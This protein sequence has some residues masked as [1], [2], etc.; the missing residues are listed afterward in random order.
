MLPTVTTSAPAP[1]DELIDA[2]RALDGVRAAASAA[3]P[4]VLRV[5]LVDGA[6]EQAVGAVV[7]ALLRDRFG[8]T[9]ETV[10]EDEIGP[11]PADG[12]LGLE[13]LVLTS[14][15]GARA[16][17]LL[18]LDGR[19]APGAADA[20]GAAEAIAA[21][22]LLALEELTE[23]AVIGTIDNVRED[24][25]GVARVR[26]RLDVDGAEVVATGEAAVVRSRVQA[27]VRALLVAIEPHLPD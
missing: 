7:D 16:E 19:T 4:G 13:R 8:V 5:E 10:V 21:A 2:V 24:S 22:L 11:M 14:G 15:G 18:G 20:D 25:D 27:V 12:R 9:S 23:D 1:S 17:V 6:D 26:L 3:E